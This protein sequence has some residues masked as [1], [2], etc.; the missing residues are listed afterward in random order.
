MQIWKKEKSSLTVIRGHDDI[1]AIMNALAHP[2][3]LE[4]LGLYDRMW[5]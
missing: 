3:Q 2:E 4:I 5:E 1:M